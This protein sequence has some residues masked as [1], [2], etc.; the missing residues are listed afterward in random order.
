[1]SDG[2]KHYD[3]LLVLPPIRETVTSS[4]NGDSLRCR[5]SPRLTQALHLVLRL[6]SPS[7]MSMSRPPNFDWCILLHL[8]R[9]RAVAPAAIA[10]TSNGGFVVVD[11]Q[12]EERDNF[13][14]GLY[15]RRGESGGG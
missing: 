6:P 4:D 8:S 10:T 9:F 3:V 2:G 15:L 1:M 13:F 5:M 12:S 7:A 11:R 14:E